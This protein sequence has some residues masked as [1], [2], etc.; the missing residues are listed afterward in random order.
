[1]NARHDA[2]AALE[3]RLGHVF[4]DRELLDRA[5]THSSAGDGRRVKDNERLEFLGDRV[6]GLLAAERLTRAYPSA[7]EGELSPRLHTLVNRDACARVAR[8]LGVGAAMRL[9]PGETRTGGRDKDTVLG[10]AM[11]AIV[12]A[13]YLDAGLDAARDLFD[14]LWADAL[15]RVD[16]PRARD[17]KSALQVWAQGQG[18]PLPAYTVVSRKGPDHAPRF[19]VEVTVQGVQPAQAEGRSRQDAEKAA[20]TALLRREGLL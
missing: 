2:V 18:K 15:A 5:L 11:E 17:V 3:Q 8:D 20:A 10:D 16:D 9:S 6:L 19:I 4:K 14:R 13:V 12:A 1:M 7:K